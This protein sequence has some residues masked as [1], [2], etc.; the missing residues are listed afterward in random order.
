MVMQHLWSVAN[1]RSSCI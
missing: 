1:S